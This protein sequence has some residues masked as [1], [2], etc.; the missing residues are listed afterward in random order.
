MVLLKNLSNDQKK[1][2]SIQTPELNKQ[3]TTGRVDIN[4]LL[5]RA[6]KKK[7]K[8]NKSNLIFYGLFA[9]IIVI[10]GIASSF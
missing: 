3:Q 9:S 7:K 1:T 2:T 5:A 4:S 10:A 8:T 6:R